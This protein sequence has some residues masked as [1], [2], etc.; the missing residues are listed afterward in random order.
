MH[1]NARVPAQ[2]QRTMGIALSV[3]AMAATATALLYGQPAPRW[4]TTWGTSQQALGTTP[5][6]N[7]TVRMIARTSIGGETIRV[8]LDNAFGREPLAI[9]GATIGI[10]VRGALLAAGS[11]KRVTFGGRP[12]VTVPPGG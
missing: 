9:G 10:R 6:S 4:V 5:V 7:A 8:R 11:A 2:R 3:A 12:D 1:S